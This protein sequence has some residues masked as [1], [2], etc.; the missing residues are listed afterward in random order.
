MD[1][2]GA[3]SPKALGRTFE[4]MV[5]PEEPDHEKEYEEKLKEKENM[6]KE[7]RWTTTMNLEKIKYRPR[8]GKPVGLKWYGDG[9]KGDYDA[10]GEVLLSSMYSIRIKTACSTI[11]TGC[12]LR[13]TMIASARDRTNIRSRLYQE[14][15]QNRP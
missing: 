10:V 3:R 14:L 6:D 12:R 11:K 13:K 7:K 2:L 8:C 1:E 5:D 15:F 9:K 4:K